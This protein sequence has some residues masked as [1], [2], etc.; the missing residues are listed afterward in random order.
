MDTNTHK[1]SL[2]RIEQHKSRIQE[3]KANPTNVQRRKVAHIIQLHQVGKN[4]TKSAAHKTD[5]VSPTM[6]G[7]S[8]LATKP[9]PKQ[10]CTCFGEHSHTKKD[11]RE[12]H[13]KQ[14]T[15]SPGKHKC[16][17]DEITEDDFDEMFA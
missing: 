6:D 8:S 10:R 2:K 9:K 3:S 17:K 7:K 5:K 11:C 4:A 12:P 15:P 16:N 1:I 13:Y 14:L